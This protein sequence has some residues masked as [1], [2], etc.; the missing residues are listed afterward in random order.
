M[1]IR[2]LRRVASGHPDAPFLP[3]A[4]IT[5]TG[6]TPEVLRWLKSGVVEIVREDMSEYAVVAVREH[7]VTRTATTW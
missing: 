3:G 6:P 1:T 2:F 7:A 4:V 5:Y